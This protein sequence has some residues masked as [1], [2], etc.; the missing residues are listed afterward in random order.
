MAGHKSYP[1]PFG[2]FNLARKWIKWQNSE[3]KGLMKK[4]KEKINK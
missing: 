1:V 4:E 3:N 2:L